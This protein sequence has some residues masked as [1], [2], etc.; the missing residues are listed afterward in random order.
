MLCDDEHHTL[1]AQYMIRDLQTVADG[2]ASILVE[3]T[4]PYP[5]CLL[6]LRLS[7][8][9]IP[10]DGRCASI[11]HRLCFLSFCCDFV[12]VVGIWLR[13]EHSQEEGLALRGV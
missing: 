6:S 8:I 9:H 1:S 3:L 7:F 10:P 12:V 11:S 5:Y 4:S 13:E 2:I